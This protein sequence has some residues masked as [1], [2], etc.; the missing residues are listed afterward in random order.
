M[1]A[2]GYRQVAQSQNYKN[3]K[4]SI[5]MKKRITV[6]LFALLLVC[7]VCFSFAA[8][9]D[10]K[11]YGLQ[12]HIRQMGNR[13]RTYLH[14]AGKQGKN[15]TKCENKE[16]ESIPGDRRSHIRRMGNRKRTYP[17]S[18]REAGKEPV[19]FAKINKRKSFRQGISTVT[20]EFVP[21]AVAR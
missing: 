9:G 7:T 1:C 18:S 11:R 15:C 3:F 10:Q 2:I 16:T 12:A 19:P 14:R 8:C 21:C 17:A 4:E 20:T 5:V 6:V 13:K